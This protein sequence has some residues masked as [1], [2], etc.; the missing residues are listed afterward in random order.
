MANALTFSSRVRR[1]NGRRAV[2]KRLIRTKLS[3]KYEASTLGYLWTILEPI[4]LTFVYAVVFGIVG[5]L[6][7]VKPFPAH[8]LSG[9]LAW[10]W[11]SGSFNASMSALR[12][13]SKLIS[14]VDLPREIYPLALVLTKGFEYLLTL[15]VIVAVALL[16]G[17]RP[18]PMMAAFPLAVLLQLML[19][20]GLALGLSA[21]NTLFRDLE[22]VTR[23]V[24]RTWFYASPIL[25]PLLLVDERVSNGLVQLIYRLNPIT[26]ILT[27]YRAAW[28]GWYR[29]E[30]G[31]TVR[32]PVDQFDGWLTV[33]YSAIGC[34][35]VL[36]IGYLL[37][38]R[39]EG[40]VLKE[41]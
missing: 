26:G 18:D 36:L 30:T 12:G 33:G 37:F 28:D 27:L 39:L 5:R 4:M 19:V 1:I 7:R 10:Q 3:L 25:Y 35:L 31:S 38:T 9:V 23:P 29:V 14:K 6:G 15:P 17:L 21:A 16:W 2:L 41:I 22:R 8:I 24:L 40:R 32:V 34:T 11:L 20:T 13:N